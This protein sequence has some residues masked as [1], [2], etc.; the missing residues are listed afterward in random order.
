METLIIYDF[1]DTL[2]PSEAYV[3]HSI[4]SNDNILFDEIDTI[5]YTT[6]MKSLSIGQVIILSDGD[7]SWLKELLSHIPKSRELIKDNIPVVSTVVH[8]QYLH[9]SKLFRNLL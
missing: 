9:I 6:L 8:Y 7:S 5:I 3:S 1:D 4:S 2:F